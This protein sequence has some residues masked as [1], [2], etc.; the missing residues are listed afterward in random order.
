MRKEYRDSKLKTWAEKENKLS[1]EY[2]QVTT[3]YET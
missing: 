2:K 1:D 3:S